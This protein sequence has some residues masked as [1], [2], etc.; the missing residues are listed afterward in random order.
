MEKKNFKGMQLVKKVFDSWFS[1]LFH[2]LEI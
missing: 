1:V 2:K